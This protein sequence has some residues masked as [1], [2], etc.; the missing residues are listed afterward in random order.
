ME[1]KLAGK[2]YKEDTDNNV[3]TRYFAMSTTSYKSD[4]PY[5]FVTEVEMKNFANEPVAAEIADPVV[6]YVERLAAKVTLN[7]S[8]DLKSENGLYK[9]N[10]TLSGDDNNEG[11][12]EEDNNIGATNIYLKFIG[13]GLNATANDSYMMKNIDTGWDDGKFSSFKWN[14]A[15]NFRSYWGKSYLY[16]DAN[17]GEKLTYKNVKGLT[18]NGIGD[19]DY[20]AENTTTATY[21]ANR[22]AVTSV[23][24]VA[25]ICD[26]EGKAL[27][28]YVRY[29]GILY[30]KASYLNYVLNSVELNL[31][32]KSQNEKGE[33]VYTKVDNKYAVLA[34]LGSDGVYAQIQ[35]PEGAEGLYALTAGTTDDYQPA[36]DFSEANNALKAFNVSK[37]S[38]GVETSSANGYKGGQMYYNIPIQHFERPVTDPVGEANYGVVRNHLYSITV[39]SLTKLGKGIYNPDEV[40]IPNEDDEKE[41]YYVGA[42]INILSWKIVSQGVDL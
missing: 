4:L 13:W 15:G 37:N 22:D 33:T 34:E 21:A 14:D 28:D 26:K 39:N 35:V 9:L 1:T 16:N 32:T 18:G 12:K 23:V 40:I 24:L 19:S 20:C 7:V 41:S 36:T 10:V 27:E 30:T 3:T 31:Y 5:Y 17:Y 38:D 8:S 25:E 11:E 29:N 2:I 6:V 42:E